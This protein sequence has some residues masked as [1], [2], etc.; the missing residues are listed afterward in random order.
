[1]LTSSPID[2]GVLTAPILQGWQEMESAE[3]SPT[4]GRVLCKCCYSLDF[5]HLGWA[6]GES[7]AAAMDCSRAG[8]RLGTTAH[9]H[10]NSL[11]LL[12]VDMQPWEAA[13]GSRLS[14]SESHR[15]D[16]QALLSARA[17]QRPAS[18]TQGAGETGTPPS[19]PPLLAPS[20][21][22]RKCRGLIFQQFVSCRL[23]YFPKTPT[24]T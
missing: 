9:A 6:V 5:S 1:M 3:K 24:C 4:Q 2:L 22:R 20:A 11:T 8:R 13:G 10:Q 18:T 19:Q 15:T 14:T 23:S 16:A 7:T 12:A 21:A 17:C